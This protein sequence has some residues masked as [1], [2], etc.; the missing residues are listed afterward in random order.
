MSP[1]QLLRFLS[2]SVLLAA[3]VQCAAAQLNDA[4]VGYP[5]ETPLV[6]EEAAEPAERKAPADEQVEQMRAKR[7]VQ[8]LVAR[9]RRNADMIPLIEELT[10]AAA[11][12]EESPMVD[13]RRNK[14]YLRYGRAGRIG[15]TIVMGKRR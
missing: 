10:V 6:H 12:D 4:E 3:C 7:L 2:V 5:L 1:T 9:Y 8:L 15:G 14:R 11:A 13:P